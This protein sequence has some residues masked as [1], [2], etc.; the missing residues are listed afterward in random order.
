MVA[1]VLVPR[2]GL[3]NAPIAG[4]GNVKSVVYTM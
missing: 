4:A 1:A 3:L 2:E